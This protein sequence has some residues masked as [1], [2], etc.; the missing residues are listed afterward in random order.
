MAWE[1][2]N[3]PLEEQDEVEDIGNLEK[4]FKTGELHDEE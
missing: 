4:Q 1:T 2:L 3:E